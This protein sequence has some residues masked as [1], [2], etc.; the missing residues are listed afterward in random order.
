MVAVAAGSLAVALGAPQAAAAPAFDS[1]GYLDSTASCAAPNE[2]VVFG[3]TSASRIAICQSPGGTLQYRGVRV[4]DG[5][6]LILPATRSGETFVADNDGVTYTVS[7]NS[8]E[9]SAGSRVIRTETMVDFHGAI[10]GGDTTETT[11]PESSAPEAD[12]TSVPE[13]PP[14][15]AEV[16][17]S[18]S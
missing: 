4:R 16:G 7:E 10:D 8:L 5:A 15:P 3:S 6:R 14:L 18:G 13:G 9:V 2:A 12:T 11:G 17:G 1:Q